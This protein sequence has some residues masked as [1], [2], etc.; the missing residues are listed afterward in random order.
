[1]QK[2]MNLETKLLKKL[3]CLKRERQLAAL[4]RK[5]GISPA[6]FTRA[7]G[8]EKQ[9]LGLSKVS[10]I[11][12]ALGAEIVFPDEKI[13]ETYDFEDYTLIPKVRA[14][15][16]AGSSLIVDDEPDGLYA[17][18]KEFLARVGIHGKK[19]GVLFGIIGD[20]MIPTF[21]PDDSVL[22]A[23]NQKEIISGKYYAIRIN[24]EIHIK[25]LE[26]LISGGLRIHSEN[27]D[28]YPPQDTKKVDDV[29]IIGRVRWSGRVF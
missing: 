16:G 7:L 19:D 14:K 25:R 1:M 18:R 6:N 21:F 29:Y 17:F 10:L 4:A 9:S 5:T 15:L 12:D 22:V 27:K 13:P 11:L 8:E 24:E 26:T 28:L 2:F 20:S 3:E 23:V